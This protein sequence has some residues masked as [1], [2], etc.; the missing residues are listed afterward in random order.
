VGSVIYYPMFHPA[1]A[2]HQPRWRSLVEED[3][4]KIPE[5]LA[6]LE[7]IEEEEGPQVTQA[8]QLSLF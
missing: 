8:E 6:K 2:L 4:L 1:A 3:I 7:E 5:L